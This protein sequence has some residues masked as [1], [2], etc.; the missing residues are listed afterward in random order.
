MSPRRAVALVLAGALLAAVCGTGADDSSADDALDVVGQSSGEAV[1]DG[2]LLPESPREDVPSALDNPIGEGLP[3][4]LVET[5][6][7]VSGGP[8]PDGIPP[9]D[10]PRFDTIDEVDWLDDNEPVLAVTIGGESRAYPVQIMIWHEI[11]N[12]QIAGVPV[13]VTYCPLCNSALV[14]DRRLTGPDGAERLVSFGTSGLLYNSDL[15]MYDRQTESLWSQ[16]IGLG[17]AGVLT[18][19]ELDRYPV[20]TLSYADWREQNPDGLVLNRITGQERNYGANPYELY[21]QESDTPF[22]FDGDAD[23]RLPPKRRVVGVATPD[24]S[25]AVAVDHAL[26][27]SEGVVPVTFDGRGLVA[28]MVSGAAS[29]LDS[30][31]IAEGRTVGST[32]VLDPVVDGQRLTLTATDDGLTDAETGST[33]TLAGAA[34]G[35]SLAGSTLEVV[36][37]TDPFWFAWA[38][39]YPDTV[40][41][42]SGQP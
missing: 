35:G 6:R 23:D 37:H 18:G 39:F 26:L 10:E 24:G 16:L 15:L 22:L 20:Q 42:D 30:G 9:V 32:A 21:D 31:T 3:Q 12:D 5:D 27:Q 4:P 17:V 36:P 38:A 29:A 28:V 40:L 8:P 33:W 41:V 2:T 34:T 19:V 13:S 1:D 11:V 25:Q 14:F 7:I